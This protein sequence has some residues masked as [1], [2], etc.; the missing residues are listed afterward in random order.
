MNQILLLVIISGWAELSYSQLSFHSLHEVLQ[1]ADKN[2]L[3]GKQSSFSQGV[4]EKDVA[5]SKSGLLPKL[6][7]FATGDYYPLIPVLVVPASATGGPSDKFQKV[8]LGLPW[9]FSS[10]V[11]LTMPVLNLAKWE[12]LKKYRLQSL[13]TGWDNKTNEETLHIQ[14]AQ[15][16]YQALLAK[17]LLELGNADVEI[18]DELLR[19]M[20]E[21][22]KNQL[23]DPAD[24]NRARNLQLD[25][26][27][28]VIDYE[29]N[30]ELGLIALRQLLH[31]P[32]E[33]PL[34]L[35]DSVSSP[36]WKSN[37]E[38]VRP[39]DRPGWK[40]ASSRVAVAEEQE[41]QSGKTGLPVLALDGKFTYQSQFDPSSTQK[42]NYAFS[43]VGLRLDF[44]I[45]QGNYYKSSRQKS[46]QQ[47]E[48]AKVSQLQT[49][50]EILRQ[51]AEWKSSFDAALRKQSVLEEKRQ[52][53]EDNLRIARINVQEGIMEFE[54]FNTI[55]HEY[56]ETRM[57][58]LQNLSDGILYKLLLTQKW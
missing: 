37:P 18:A 11:E 27:N 46:A 45:F 12:E 28:A 30:Y 21:R 58:Y 48:S 24:Y 51:Q 32:A 8:Q 7:V 4:A 29:K 54:T 25:T 13:Q 17:G 40:G 35:E 9:S 42:L 31:L 53:T 47:L 55:F 2:S 50:D 34:T 6:N 38:A 23:V 22:N 1:Y 3:V 57:S 14:L 19:I 41:K 16:Y 52:L 5:I 10:G 26:R 39:E 49:E 20:A 33:S 56:I 15:A 44:P 36:D 43:N